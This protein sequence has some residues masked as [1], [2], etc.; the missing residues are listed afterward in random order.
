MTGRSCFNGYNRRLG[1]EVSNG[2]N[3]LEESSN[4]YVQESTPIQELSIPQ[5]LEPSSANAI[6]TGD[7][8]HSEL[9]GLHR[10]GHFQADSPRPRMSNKDEVLSF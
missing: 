7:E 4:R 5:I 8:F 6:S 10:Q 3:S 9:D 2:A 1:K